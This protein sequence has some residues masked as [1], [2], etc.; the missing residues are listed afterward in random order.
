MFRWSRAVLATAVSL[1]DLG[2]AFA[3]L[4]LSSKASQDDVRKSYLSLARQH[5]PD[6][7]NGDDSV[8]KRIN[9]AYEMLSSPAAASCMK[10]AAEAQM[11]QA[12]PGRQEWSKP[13]NK[14]R[15]QLDRNVAT[16]DI[17]M[18][19]TDL[20]WETAMNDISPQDLKNPANH[21]LSP[22]K[23]FSFED[24]QAIFKM[25]RSGASVRQVAKTLGLEVGMIERRLSNAQFKQRISQSLKKIK[26]RRWK[27]G[28][29]RP[30]QSKTE[31]QRQMQEAVWHEP[32][33]TQFAQPSDH[34]AHFEGQPT[35]QNR[36]RNYD[37]LYDS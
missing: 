7:S 24:D 34:A 30:S 20:D 25:M 12:R 2:K 33:E 28:D 22:S 13:T 9:A 14:R 11:G 4:G 6:L 27:E 21:P 23:H 35:R 1:E 19:R 17:W 37:R 36:Y 3:E 16:A 32:R 5:H 15:S 10:E 29:K 8:M 18:C 31:M 26:H